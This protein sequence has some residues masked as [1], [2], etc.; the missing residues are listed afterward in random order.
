MKLLA[1]ILL[2]LLAGFA[3]ANTEPVILSIYGD[4]VLD[5]GQYQ[6]LDF[7]L[8]ELQALAQAEVI[9]A[10]PWSAEVHHYQGIDLAA[11]LKLLF[12]DKEIKNLNLEGLNGFSMALEWSKISDFSPILAFQEDGNLMSRR[13]KG[14]LWL[15]LAYDQAPKVQQAD[16]LHY[17]VWQLRTIRVYSESE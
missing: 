14:P 3:K 5:D 12:A 1:G 9:T 8:S 17:M 15:M 13:N 10:H 11:L 16:F 2:V 7:T 6:R 4:I